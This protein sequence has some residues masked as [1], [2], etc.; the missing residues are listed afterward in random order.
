MSYTIS[1]LKTP[2]FAPSEELVTEVSEN[3]AFVSISERAPPPARASKATARVPK[4]SDGVNLNVK[5]KGRP[6]KSSRA[7][8]STTSSLDGAVGAMMNT[9]F[10]QNDE[11]MPQ[12]W[13]PDANP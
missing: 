12:A 6:S 10:D 7:T 1:F 5:K 4:A 3:S 13:N 9:H 8:E 11:K 2:V